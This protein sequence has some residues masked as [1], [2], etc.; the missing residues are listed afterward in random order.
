MAAAAESS[1]P[2]DSRLGARLQAARRQLGQRTERDHVAHADERGRRARLTR[3]AARRPTGRR[4]GCWQSGWRARQWTARPRGTLPASR[5]A[6]RRRRRILPAS[7][8]RRPGDG[9]RL[10]RWRVAASTPLAPSTSTHECRAAEPHGRPNVTNGMFCWSSQSVRLSSVCVSGEHE[11]VQVVLAEQAL[12]GGDLRVVVLDRVEQSAESPELG[13]ISRARAGI[14]APPP[15]CL[16]LES[17]VPR[18]SG[19]SAGSAA[20]APP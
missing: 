14:R 18:R 9:R 10:I 8:G 13:A 6:C 16:R 15:L 12:V 4:R 20:S 11:A 17:E 19:T 3:A 2:N 5:S 7:R 1:N